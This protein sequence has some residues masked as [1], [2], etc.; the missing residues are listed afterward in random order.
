MG[1]IRRFLTHDRLEVLWALAGVV[2]LA[3][4]PHDLCEEV[5]R[6]GFVVAANA[7]LALILAPVR[8]FLAHAGDTQPGQLPM[9]CQS[10]RASVLG[11]RNKLDGFLQDAFTPSH[12]SS[13][14]SI[15]VVSN[16]CPNAAGQ[17]E[18]TAQDLHAISW[19]RS[20]RQQT[21]AGCE[22]TEW[23]CSGIYGHCS[24]RRL[25]GQK[26]IR[27]ETCLLTGEEGEF[28]PLPLTCMVAR[29]LSMRS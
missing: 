26:K 19:K 11:F 6:V 27:M 23:P 5:P 10:H 4:L 16:S 14:F 17:D 12:L 24:Q 25:L 9:S 13:I 29:G 15:P 20:V 8:C 21:A 2:Q 7:W 1:F 18:R 22:Q 3:Q 28:K